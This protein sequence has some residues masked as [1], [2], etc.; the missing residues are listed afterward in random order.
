M[1]LSP[2]STASARETPEWCAFDLP[3]RHS[4]EGMAALHRFLSDNS[5]AW[6]RLSAHRLRRLDSLLLQYLAAAARAWAAKGCGFEIVDLSQSAAETMTL[7]GAQA[8]L[9]KGK[10]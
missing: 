1:R 6:I 2:K 5:E 10:V 8:D 9:L 4:A 3:E 7:L